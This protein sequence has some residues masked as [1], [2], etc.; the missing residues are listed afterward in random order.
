ME[1]VCVCRFKKRN[2]QEGKYDIF[3]AL[4]G[5]GNGMHPSCLAASGVGTDPSHYSD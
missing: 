5:Y 1:Y 4:S 2:I 3:R